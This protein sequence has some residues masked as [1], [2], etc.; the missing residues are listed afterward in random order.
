[1][2]IRLKT[3]KNIVNIVHTQTHTYCFLNSL[4]TSR[5][6]MRRPK[7]NENSTTT[8]ARSDQLYMESMESQLK[9]SKNYTYREKKCIPGTSNN[10]NAH[11][12]SQ[13][14]EIR[15]EKEKKVAAAKNPLHAPFHKVNV[16][17]CGR[18]LV[19]TR[20][21]I[22]KENHPKARRNQSEIE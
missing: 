9:K 13:L 15:K 5:I 1:M 4:V 19:F 21:L 8:E 22:Y 14:N 11:K 18:L 20:S 16:C 3:N 17:V 7:L 6:K 2:P 12:R 10:R